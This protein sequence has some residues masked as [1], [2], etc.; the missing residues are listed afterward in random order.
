VAIDAKDAAVGAAGVGALYLLSARAGG[1]D[2]GGPSR[3]GRLPIPIPSGGGGGGLSPQGKA[4]IAR[5]IEQQNALNERLSQLEGGGSSG[6]G[7]GLFDGGG[8][9]GSSLETWIDAARGTG[10]ATDATLDAGSGAVDFFADTIGGDEPG[11]FST[12]GGITG[13]SFRSGQLTGETLDSFADFVGGN[14]PG[15]FSTTGGLTGKSYDAGRATRQ[16]LSDLNPLS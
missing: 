11:A 14:A 9:G 8:S 12:T 6:G 2:S 1:G 13:A 10:Q 4:G 15:A 7:G 3:P 5:I 16:A